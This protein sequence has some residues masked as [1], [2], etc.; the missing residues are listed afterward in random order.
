MKGGRYLTARARDTASERAHN[1]SRRKTQRSAHFSHFETCRSASFELSVTSITFQKSV[2]QSSVTRSPI[3]A[4][5]R[6]RRLVSSFGKTHMRQILCRAASSAG[7]SMSVGVSTKL[8]EDTDAFSP[9]K[10]L[11]SWSG[12][13]VQQNTVRASRGLDAAHDDFQSLRKNVA[14]GSVSGKVIRRP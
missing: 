11:P 12:N 3:S 13:V 6:N 14:G 1:Y 8:T 4:L 9:A 5:I 2:N 10:A 7:R